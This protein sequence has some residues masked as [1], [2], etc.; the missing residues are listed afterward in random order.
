M[1][2]RT[3]LKNWK[4][5][6]EMETDPDK[7]KTLDFIITKKEA[8]YDTIKQLILEEFRSDCLN[9]II[10]F[11]EENLVK[12]TEED[13]APLLDDINIDEVY[14]KME[15]TDWIQ[16]KR[17]IRIYEIVIELIKDKM[18]YEYVGGF[19]YKKEKK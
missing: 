9:A 16:Y 4:V 13:F 6:R 8:E 2:K 3:S 12:I 18:D 15:E 5:F 11:P 10:S 17:F 14:K 19:L 1:A 7:I